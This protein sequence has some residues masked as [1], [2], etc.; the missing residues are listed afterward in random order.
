MNPDHTAAQL[1]SHWLAPLTVGC[2]NHI[3]LLLA[4]L[5]SIFVL[6]WTHP[7][8]K[9]NSPPSPPQAVS[10]HTLTIRWRFCAV[11]E[12]LFWFYSLTVSISSHRQRQG[13]CPKLLLLLLPKSPSLSSIYNRCISSPHTCQHLMELQCSLFIKLIYSVILKKDEAVM[14]ADFPSFQ[15]LQ[16]GLRWDALKWMN[17]WCISVLI[18]SF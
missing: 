9:A 17:V 1:H 13:L 2:I 3:S 15:L 6:Y 18:T 16:D 4:K 7:P 8:V 11:E 5:A 14:K 12:P 10:E